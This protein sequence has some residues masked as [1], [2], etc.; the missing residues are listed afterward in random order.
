MSRR[1]R[2]DVYIGL[3]RVRPCAS[4]RQANLLIEHLP[5]ASPV[6]DE[7]SRAIAVQGA[8]TLLSATN[9]TYLV[10]LYRL[11]ASAFVLRQLGSWT[12]ATVSLVVPV[13][14][15][16]SPLLSAI[17]SNTHACTPWA[18]R[19]KEP[20]PARVKRCPYLSKC[21][22]HQDPLCH[23]N[24]LSGL[25]RKPSTSSESSVDT[26]QCHMDMQMQASQPAS[27]TLPQLKRPPVVQC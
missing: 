6:I 23:K 4:T 18:A 14:I 10:L 15:H 25:V 27:S 21:P 8:A 22:E 16:N 2:T 20:V 1:H 19:R 13:H 24:C 11:L 12:S 3:T 26:A 7:Q 5:S 9:R 17:Y